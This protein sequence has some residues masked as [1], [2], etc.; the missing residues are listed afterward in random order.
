MKR[1]LLFICLLYVSITSYSQERP[2]YFFGDITQAEYDL[3]V[4]EKDSTANAVVL[5]EYGKTKFHVS[6]RSIVI[7]RTYY[8][9]VKIFNKEGE[10][11]AI[12]KIPIY[13]NQKEKEKV[14]K[15]KAVTHNGKVKKGLNPKNIFVGSVSNNWAE[16]KFTMPNVQKN[17]IIEY[18]YTLESPFIFNFK[19]WEFQSGIPKIYSEFHASIPGNYL[20]RRRLTG[21]QKLSKSDIKVKEKCFTVPYSYRQA[22]CEELTYAMEHI[23]AFIE[24]DFLTTKENYL[25]AIKFELSEY[26][27]FDGS[28]K[29]YTKNWKNVDKE[30]RTEK[31]IGKQLKKVDYMKKNLPKELLKGENNIARAKKIYYYINDH[32]TWN[33]QIK[34]FSNSNGKDVYL[35]KV[36]NSTEI[37]ISLINALNAAGFDA[38]IVLLSTRNN[39]LPTKLYP[40]LS[41]FNYA[42]VKL[43]IEGN[44]YLLDATTKNMP[45]NMLPFRTLNSYGRVMDFRKGSYWHPIQAK[46]NNITRTSLNLKMKENGNFIGQ[47]QKSYD[48]YRAM[49]KRKDINKLDEDEYISKAEEAYG[50]D[51]NLVINAYKNSNVANIEK[52]LKELYDVTIENNSGDN[53]IIFNP[54]FDGETGVNP[55][56]LNKRSYPVDFGYATTNLF[57]LQLAIPDNYIVKSLPKDKG[58]KLPNDGGQFTFSITEKNNKIQ[59]TLKVILKRSLY[60]PQEY[61]YLK[62]FF[63]QI[64]KT[65]KSLITLEKK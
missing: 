44:S 34:L 40:V 30:F 59:M 62:E 9:K 11:N 65:Q 60:Q 58:L 13:N 41:E 45:F 53:L 15:I 32:Y 56:K 48:G 39:G 31:S 22:D 16:V 5:F 21:Y 61:P 52:P 55:F 47:M 4:Y 63:N 14:F 2:S 17:S 28:R 64:I 36:G 19:G 20:Y 1:V 33:E 46:S 25:S 51:D 3:N 8:A 50:I 27:G 7:R 24:E 12:I 42:I 43:N 38:Q 35:K 26:K 37:N 10:D 23:P 49:T 29:K 57:I 6:N 54:F 18:E